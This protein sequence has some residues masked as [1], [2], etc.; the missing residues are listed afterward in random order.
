MLADPAGRTQRVPTKNVSRV[1]MEPSTIR[2]RA[3]R[4]RAG[5]RRGTPPQFH[6]LTPIVQENLELVA[7]R[8]Q[9]AGIL[10]AQH[11]QES[12]CEDSGFP[13]EFSIR[14]VVARGARPGIH[15]PD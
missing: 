1:S 7:D 14:W 4:V 15:T 6:L 9:L 2:N 13:R 8:E 10:R 12:D 5:S 11:E 3:P